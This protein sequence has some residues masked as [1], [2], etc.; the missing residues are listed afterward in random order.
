MEIK[1]IK[2]YVKENKL[3]WTN[4]VFLRI[5]QRS[6]SM[7]DICTA[8]LCGEIIEEYPD[9]YPSPSCLVLGFKENNIAIHIVCGIHEGELWIITAYHPDSDR[10][11]SDLR[12]R[13]E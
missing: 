3:R 5:T 11:S 4:H 7:K 8:L 13:K 6:I 1:V 2:N 9:D 12:T 10:W